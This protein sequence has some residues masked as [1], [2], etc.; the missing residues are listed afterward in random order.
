MSLSPWT[1]VA[2]SVVAWTILGI[3]SGVAVHALPQQRLDHDTWLTRQRAFEADGRWYERTLR[4]RRWKDRLPEGGAWLPGGVSKTRLPG[5]S[6]ADLAGFAAETRRAEIVHW[7]NLAAGPWFF[8]W[9][10]PL[11]GGSMVAFGV[12][13]HTPFICVQRYNRARIAPTTAR[14]SRRAN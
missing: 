8:I 10:P 5:R 3:V 13:A 1:A 2:V 4:I 6:D 12:I 7:V 11:I 14:R 9:C